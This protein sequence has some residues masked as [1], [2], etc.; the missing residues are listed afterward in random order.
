MANYKE[1]EG[2]GVQT[3]ATD[4]DT[5]GWIGSIFYNS[6][7]GTFK[8]VKPGGAPIGTWSSGGTVNTARNSLY[9]TGSQTA[10]L[11]YSGETTVNVTNVES[12]N[13]TSWTEITD[14]NTAL[15]GGASAGTSTS[16]L[17]ID[18][19]TGTAASGTVESWNGTSWTEIAELN[20]SRID[21]S[22][23]GISNTAAIIFGG[24]TPAPTRVANTE[25]WNGTSWTE[26]ND[27]NAATSGLRGGGTQTSAL[28]TGGYAPGS[29]S[30]KTESWNGT[31]WTE[32]SDLNLARNNHAY[33]GSNN[34]N[35]L[36]FAGD[37]PGAPTTV[38]TEFYDGTS[39]TEVNNLAT[40]KY[41]L[42]G[43]SNIGTSTS[44]L[45]SAGL[46]S[47]DINTATTEEWTAPDVVI[48]TL[49]TS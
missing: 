39:W 18:G 35:G 13:G 20:T 9:S 10:N 1:L 25:S 21:S 44:A 4:P 31:S 5:P 45:A 38:N 49:T 42:A 36:V 6:T 30:T 17:K 32:V 14:V 12:Y 16:A 3:L 23:A 29:R 47:S 27:L 11:I 40:S 34:T 28:A 22:A 43:S 48:N 19:Y 41:R 33:S 26:V 2:F 46:N 8:V 15:R 7:S 37:N 24:S